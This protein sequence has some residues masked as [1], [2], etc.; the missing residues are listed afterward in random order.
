M[1]EGPETKRSQ[2]PGRRFVWWGCGFV[3]AAF[4]IAVGFLLYIGHVVV[5]FYEQKRLEADAVP[6]EISD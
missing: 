2:S 3:I 6:H 5:E 4:L 1:S